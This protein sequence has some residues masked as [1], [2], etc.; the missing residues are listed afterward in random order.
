MSDSE[1][2]YWY[3]DQD[4]RHELTRSAI[5]AQYYPYWREQM[6]KIPRHQQYMAEASLEDQHEACLGDW[7]IVNWAT[8]V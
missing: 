6:L 7:I 4:G 3:E 2:R 5:I 1:D 8:K